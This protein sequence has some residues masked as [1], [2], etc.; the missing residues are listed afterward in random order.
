MFALAVF[1]GML[2]LP[3]YLQAV[4]GE[5]R[6]RHRPAAGAAGHRRD[7]H[8][9]DRRAAD[10]PDR[11]RA[12]RARRAGVIVAI[13][14]LALTQL[15]ADTSYW[16]LG[17]VLFVM[18]LGMGA[19]MMPTFS[20]AMQT[21]RRAAV[22]RASTSLN[23]TAAGRRLDRH[24]GHGVLLANALAS[25]PAGGR[26]HRRW[27]RRGPADAVRERI[28]PLMAEAFG[29]TFWWATGFVV[30]AFALVTPLLP[31]RSPS[32]STTRTTPT[33]TPRR[34]RPCR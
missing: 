22:A 33:A 15:E 9:A 16:A 13:S 19:T 26:R 31:A 18:G 2:L 1:G 7:D 6:D 20:G 11:R 21:L 12:D 23:I 25:P 4:R 17:A 8:D 10:R 29:E 3:L 32:R 27:R 24:G 28:A 34:M 30:I 14:F 5:S